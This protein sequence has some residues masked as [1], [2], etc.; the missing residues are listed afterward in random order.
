MR[1]AVYTNIET[2]L[3]FEKSVVAS[4]DPAT[5]LDARRTDPY[6][7]ELSLPTFRED[8]AVRYA[9]SFAENV[10]KSTQDTS[11]IVFTLPRERGGGRG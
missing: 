9:I 10:G 7:T 6:I 1:L 11:S 3:S 4:D 2:I 8:E 5:V